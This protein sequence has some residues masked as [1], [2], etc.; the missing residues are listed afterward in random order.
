MVAR[1][2]NAMSASRVRTARAAAAVERRCAT[3]Y[4]DPTGKIRGI[5]STGAGWL[6]MRG[7]LSGWADPEPPKTPP[8]PLRHA[9]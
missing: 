9:R 4:R 2:H 8:S 1:L 7:P 5:R 6:A 3:R